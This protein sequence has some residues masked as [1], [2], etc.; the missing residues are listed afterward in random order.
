MYEHQIF[1]SEHMQSGRL[2]D[3]DEIFA[4][5][6]KKCIGLEMQ[7]IPL[8]F[9]PAISGT[10]DRTLRSVIGCFLPKCTL[11]VVVNFYLFDSTE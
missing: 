3:H 5:F 9:P 8:S 1:F 4:K 11:G 2:G 7:T 10:R 6:D